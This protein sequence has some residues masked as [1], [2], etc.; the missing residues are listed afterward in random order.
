M[1]FFEKINLIGSFRIMF[2]SKECFQ[3]ILGLDLM[4]I[5]RLCIQRSLVISYEHKIK[6]DIYVTSVYTFQL[7]HISIF[8]QPSSRPKSQYDIPANIPPKPYGVNR[9]PDIVQFRHVSPSFV[10]PLDITIYSILLHISKRM[11]ILYDII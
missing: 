8:I 2:T 6:V 4:G 9:G 1:K 3:N 10:S 11:Y 7:C 5:F